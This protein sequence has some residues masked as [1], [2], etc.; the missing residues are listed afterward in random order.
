M[1]ARFVAANEN[2]E[3]FKYLF[4]LFFSL[5][6]MQVIDNLNATFQSLKKSVSALIEI[7]NQ[8][9]SVLKASQTDNY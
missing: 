5:D 6:F 9:I 8:S 3:E 1:R 2:M 4:L 7:T